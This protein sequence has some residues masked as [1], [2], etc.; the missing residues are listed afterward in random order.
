LR[1]RGALSLFEAVVLGAVQGI[2]EFLP[3]SSSGHLVLAEYLLK[4]RFDDIS[5][6]VFVHLGTFFS[7]VL[8]FRHTIVSILRALRLQ[9][10]SI[11]GGGAKHQTVQP[12]DARLFWLI[13]AGSVPA[14]VAGLLLKTQIEKA[15]ASATL[16][17]VMLL[18]TGVILLLTT[19]FKAPRKRMNLPDALAVGVAQALAILPGIS[20][21]G[22]TISAGIFRGVERSKAAEYSFLLSLPAILG[23]SL[24]ELKEMLGNPGLQGS[25]WVY[26][27]GALTAFGVG[28]VAIRFLLSIIRKG[29]FQYF[30]CYC[31]ALGTF[32]LIFLK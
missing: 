19:F 23:A 15:F 8:V 4:V 7:V 13:L 24:I 17:A 2:T 1:K 16:V 32:F 28:Y 3:I 26:L 31:L 20:R 29:K 9:I 12:E 6:E 22:T 5:F 14:G 21:S 30:G 11:I 18:V 10:I 27:A 25:L